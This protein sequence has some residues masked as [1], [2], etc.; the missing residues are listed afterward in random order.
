MALELRPF[1]LGLTDRFRGLDSRDGLLVGAE[2]RWAEFSPFADY[3]E[4]LRRR[5]AAA[6]LEALDGLWPEPVRSKVPVNVTVPAV[7]PER[8]HRLVSESGCSTAKVKIG[9]EGDEARVEA[10]RD[11]L[12]PRGRLRVDVNAQWDVE[13]A[14]RKL[15]SLRRYDL[16]YAEQ[17]VATLDEMRVL[18]RKVDVPLAVDESLRTAEDPF[19]VDVEGAADV[20]V[21][22]VAPLGGVRAAMRLAESLP[23][24]VVISSALESSI[25]LAAG[26]ACAAAIEDLRYACGLATSALFDEDLVTEPLRPVDGAIQVRKPELD[27][28][29][30]ERHALEGPD[31]D[32]LVTWFREATR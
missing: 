10:V 17:P 8:A 9:D 28:D 7:S 22:K 30:L 3:P 18:R 6:T 16:E 26:I 25:G 11:A 31:A 13:G 14:A 23:V 1:R 4:T 15:A 5:W 24:P 21:L 2:G 29:S 12:G 32:R 19:S 27:A 20:A